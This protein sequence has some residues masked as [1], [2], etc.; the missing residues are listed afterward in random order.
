MPVIFSTPTMSIIG[1][2]LLECGTEEQKL[3]YIPAFLRGDELWVQFMSEP[4]GG[5]DMAAP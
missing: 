1:P 2:T 4:S 3:R 5:S